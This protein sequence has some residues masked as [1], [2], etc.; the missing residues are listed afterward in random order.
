MLVYL[1][2][3]QFRR[4]YWDNAIHPKYHAVLE[5]NY[6]HR[7]ME[8]LEWYFWDAFS[9]LFSSEL[10]YFALLAGE[11]STFLEF[12]KIHA[13][14]LLHPTGP[15]VAHHGPPWPTCT[16][17]MPAQPQRPKC[18][19]P[20]PVVAGC[21]GKLWEPTFGASK[22]ILD[23]PDKQPSEKW[24]TQFL[25]NSSL[26]NCLY[27]FLLYDTKHSHES[28]AADGLKQCT[29]VQSRASASRKVRWQVVTTHDWEW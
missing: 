7:N 20:T 24:K 3:S 10:P 17:K 14:D 5:N 6:Q 25:P 23:D 11:S 16:R 18:R 22:T 8:W 28:R 15:T 21:D 13:V 9:L 4:K 26:L 29:P 27:H 19:C 2:G 12:P 1:L